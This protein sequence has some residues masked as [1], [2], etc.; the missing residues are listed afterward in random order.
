MDDS[1]TNTKGAQERIPVVLNAKNVGRERENAVYIG[2]PGFWGNP[3]VIGRDGDRDAV[4]AK[5]RA[6]I[7]KQPD[8]MMRAQ[9]ELKGKDLICWC[10]PEGCHGDVL[11]EVA[12]PELAAKG[13]IGTRRRSA[14]SASIAKAASPAPAI[15]GDLFGGALPEIAAPGAAAN[16]RRALSLEELKASGAILG[17][18]NETRWLSN[19]APV[20]VV[21]D[22]ET[23]PSVEHA[24]QAA[25]TLSAAA[26]T[27][28]RED[29]NPGAAKRAGRTVPMRPDWDQVKI[30][31]MQDLL[32]QKF[33]QEPY[34][35]KLKQTAGRPIVEL[36]T[37]GDRFW[38]AV[39]KDGVV[40]G[41]N[42]LGTSLEDIRLELLGER[43]ADRG[44]TEHAVKDAA[45]RSQNA[46]GRSAKKDVS[47]PGVHWMPDGDIFTENLD[48]VINCV[49]CVGV[50]GKGLAKSMADK[51]PGILAPYK[52]ACNEGKLRP[53]TILP[54]LIDRKT[55]LQSPTGNLL[56][57]NMATKDDWRDPS[58]L[59]WVARA[60]KVLP[61]AMEKRKLRSIGIP[62]M[63]AGLGGLDWADVAPLVAE[64]F[65]DAGDKKIRVVVFGGAPREEIDRVAQVPQPQTSSQAPSATAISSTN[66]SPT[67][68]KA[69]A[70]ASGGR[71]YA[72]VGARDTP[73][74]TLKKMED[75]AE[76]LAVKGWTLR[77]GAAEG[78]DSAFEA[79]ADRAMGAKQVFIPWNGFQERWDGKNSAILA[80]GEREQAIAAQFHPAWDRLTRGPRALM[81]RNSAQVLGA[82]LNSPADVLI[83]WTK[84]GAVIG[85]TGQAL[86]MAADP[87][88]AVPVINLGDPRFASLTAA[89]IVLEATRIA[90]IGRRS[91]ESDVARG[92][93]A[94]EKAAVLD[95]NAAKVAENMFKQVGA[96]SP[97]APAPR[98]AA[99]AKPSL[100][101]GL[102]LDL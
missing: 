33:A 88:Y 78:A 95:R 16:T 42:M 48:A 45:Q 99:P 85:G 92:K 15:Q 7:E 63:G 64:A 89:E 80:S 65:R 81:A 13:L 61:S 12:N 14:G 59:E 72:G 75:I 97:T 4:V 93:K 5:Y 57:L 56:V 52:K 9:K 77:S 24:Y 58:K 31:A 79:G 98:S 91:Q 100:A 84:G 19:F 102:D 50:M 25:K 51:Y 90:E 94:D 67:H 101:Q 28:I 27:A 47:G 8:L 26:R 3:F 86:R 2:R 62:K 21:L 82:D 35:E 37:W 55:G 54:V 34:A 69:A 43:I 20:N 39:E 22:G 46:T 36:N 73:P 87:R 76:I 44:A 11:S 40:A 10:S 66:H 30:Q 71:F 60:V 49:N 53:G 70:T 23:Y 96:A 74:E 1:A 18:Q 32:R 29:A 6:W 83:G 17:F 68:A 41:R 38:G